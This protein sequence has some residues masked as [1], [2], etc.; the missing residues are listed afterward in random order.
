M[1]FDP[2]HC[3]FKYWPITIIII[4]AMFDN[5]LFNLIKVRKIHV[6]KPVLESNLWKLLHEKGGIN[7]ISTNLL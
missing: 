5:Y 4:W 7:N 2:A 6:Q 3:A 1:W